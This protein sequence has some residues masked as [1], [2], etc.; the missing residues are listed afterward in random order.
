L[1]KKYNNLNGWLIAVQIFMIVKAFIW[2]RNVQLYLGILD[3]KDNLLSSMGIKDPHLYN[4]FVYF[5]LINSFLCLSFYIMLIYY[6]FKR[7]HFF[8]ML[9]F[10]FLISEFI[11]NIISA[12]IFIQIQPMDS[13]AIWS[14]LVNF[15]IALI[16][17]LYIKRS[18]RVKFTF[19]K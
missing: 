14:L 7:S 6:M 17:L 4:I 11:F 10:I 12:L 19:V 1:N 15:I 5:E 9:V 3:E 13:S 18:E 16:I 2:I 8:P